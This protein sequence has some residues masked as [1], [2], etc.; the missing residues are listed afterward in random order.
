MILHV[1]PSRLNGSLAVPGSKS[2]TIRGV[3]CG[4]MADGVSVLKNPLES[5]DTRAAAGAARS[6][7]AEVRQFPDH[8][9]IRGCG[10]RF[11]DPGKTIDM[12]NSGTSLRLFFSAGARQDFP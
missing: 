4:I 9:E 11:A 8:W 12:L 3:L 2:H 6:I 1:K 7:G 10:G 5:D